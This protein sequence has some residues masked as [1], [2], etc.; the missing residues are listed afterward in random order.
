MTTNYVLHICWRASHQRHEWYSVTEFVHRLKAECRQ[1]LQK[2]EIHLDC[3]SCRNTSL[4]IGV[5]QGCDEGV[6]Q[7]YI[8]PWRRLWWSLIWRR[9]YSF[10]LVAVNF[11]ATGVYYC[12]L[13]VSMLYLNISGSWGA[14]YID[15]NTILK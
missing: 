10:D 6:L 1:L 14:Q 4:M 9:P 2:G 15:P 11:V 13:K 5:I 3:W 8:S 7:I 12:S